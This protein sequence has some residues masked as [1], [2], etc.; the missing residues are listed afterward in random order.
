MKSGIVLSGI[1]D[2]SNSLGILLKNTIE[3]AGIALQ[4]AIAEAEGEA[5]VNAPWT[6]RTGNARNSITGVYLGKNGGK[7]ESA[8]FIGMEYGVFL[9]LANGGKYQIVWNTLEQEGTRLPLWIR[10]SII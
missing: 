6:D 5:K 1:D 10:K 7:L 4:G 8:L 3:N 9:E 2:M